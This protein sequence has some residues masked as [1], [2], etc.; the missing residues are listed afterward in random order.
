MTTTLKPLL[1]LLLAPLFVPAGCAAASPGAPRPA[2]PAPNMTTPA[3]QAEPAV[4]D[5]APLWLRYPAISPDGHTLAFNY[6]G[7]IYTVPAAGGTAVPLTLHDSYAFHP[8]WSHD[9]EWIAFASDRHGS[10]DVFVI[11]AAGGE[12]RRLTYH[13]AQDVPTDFMPDGSA[14]LFSSSRMD[15]AEA[16]LFPS[17]V[18][19]ELYRVP[20][21]G[22]RPVQVLTTPAEEARIAA[23]D[24]RIVYQD[25]K[26]YEDEWRKHHTSS[27]T[28]DIFIYDPAAGTHTRVSAFEGEDRDPVWSP[29]EDAVL[30]LSEAGGSFNVWRASASDPSGAE[31]ITRHDRHPVRFLSVADDGTLAYSWN[32]ELY[33]RPAGASPEKVAVELRSELEQQVLRN[34]ELGREATEMALSPDGKEIALVI[35]GEVFVTSTDYATTKRVTSTPTQERS[36]SFSPDGRCVLYAAE[37][38]TSWDVLESCIARDEEPRFTGATILDERTV[39]ATQAEEFQPEYSPDGSEVAYLED[40]TTLRVVELESGE[41]RTVLPGSYNY[42]YAD[43]DQWYA[44]S[45][46]GQWFL[47]DY[48]VNER[49]VSEVGLVPASGDAEPRNLTLSG[50]ADSRAKWVGNGMVIWFTDRQGMRS[51]GSWGSQADVY[52][53]FLT[54]AALDRFDLSKEEWELLQ[55]D[56]EDEGEAAGDGTAAEPRG[57]VEIELDGIEDRVRRLTIHSSA[58]A[59]ATVT[60]DGSKL[61]YL[62]RFEGGHDLWVHDFRERETR[63]VA[64]LD[65]Q[66]GQLALAGDGARAFVLSQGGITRVDLESG[67]RK[68]V[69]LAAEMRLDLPAERAYL[70][71]HVWRQ[72]RE[73]FYDPELHGV[74]WDRFKTEYGRFLPHINNNYDF[75]EMLSELLGELNASHT[76]A[77]FRGGDGED[78]RTAA[79][80]LIYDHDHTGAGLVIDEVLDGGPL[81]NAESRVR[82]GHVITGIDG[83]TLTADRNPFALLNRRQDDPVLLA[84]RDPESGD[85]WDEV[86]RPISLGAEN[87][88]LYE[89]WVESRRALVDERSD[90]RLGYV[91]VRAMN[92]ASFR[93]TYSE[94]LGRNADK[95][96]LVVDT[97][98]NGGGWLHDDLVT[99]LSGEQYVRMAPRGQRVGSEPQNKWQKPSVVVVSE[100]NYS[101]AHFFPWAYRELDVG[102]IVGTPVP[103][104]ATAVWWERLQDPTLVF[105]IP[106][107]GMLD[108]DGDY[109]ENQQLEPDHAVRNDWGSAAAGRDK[110]LEKA[111]EVLLQEIGAP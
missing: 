19:P 91:H 1:A 43:G 59:D 44:W 38:G 75:A 70:F 90:G 24:G 16:S 58:L 21:T 26:G 46:D 61:V 32:G 67:E 41:V 109:L 62:S 96:G 86:V 84:L 87:Q 101:D 7:R 23:T 10:F 107:V 50:Y 27:V 35:R 81:D 39:V 28:R 104:T 36:V 100:S 88:L 48:L 80:G 15:A 22:G 79:L 49:W 8:V 77:R 14:V 66:G 29:G 92:D 89:R 102:E 54:Q 93:T 12:A 53:M 30:W 31:Q 72:V 106:Q 74:D 60:P 18:L 51:H 11:P 34:E 45:P 94:A 52:G 56:E 82:A 78:D 103:G 2:G 69:P 68:P 85:R 110:Q 5:A 6:R 17:G 99:F 3:Q 111:V 71:E 20:V 63:L 97:R 108:A 4:R 55:E 76:G 33:L 57:P 13:S 9:G 95:E 65:A 42:S 37:R 47:V 83:E 64:K 105:G 25:R 98:F 73:K 40:R